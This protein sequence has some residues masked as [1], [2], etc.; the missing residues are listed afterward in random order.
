MG[1]APGA[2]LHPPWRTEINARS[3]IDNAKLAPFVTD[4]DKQAAT[5]KKLSAAA[6]GISAWAWI[7]PPLSTNAAWQS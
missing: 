6:I 7:C 1:A 2:K 4:G 3:A 5:H